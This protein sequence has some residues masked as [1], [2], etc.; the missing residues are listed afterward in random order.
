MSDNLFQLS[1]QAPWAQLIVFGIKNIENRG[2]NC[3]EKYLGKKIY[4]Q[5]SKGRQKISVLRDVYRDLKKNK[6]LSNIPH[7]DGLPAIDNESTI[8]DIGKYFHDELWKQKIIGSTVIY[9]TSDG[10]NTS[11]FYNY[12]AQVIKVLYSHLHAWWLKNATFWA[13][14]KQWVSSYGQT[15][16]VSIKAAN[17]KKGHKSAPGRVLQVEY[18]IVCFFFSCVFLL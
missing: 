16:I 18:D 10:M 8:K 12:P 1:V 15:N 6:Y 7:I 11:F 4:I 14:P 13:N 2:H 5:V 9:R 17:K 3:P